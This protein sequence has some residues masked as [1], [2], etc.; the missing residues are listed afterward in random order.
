MILVVVIVGAG[1]VAVVNANPPATI[2]DAV[3]EGVLNTA[4]VSLLNGLISRLPV[5]F[6]REVQSILARVPFLYSAGGASAA[7]IVP[8][9]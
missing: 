5:E 7:K 6:D 1:I 9:M 8:E 3:P 4:V 2:A